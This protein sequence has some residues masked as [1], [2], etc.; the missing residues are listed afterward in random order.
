[1]A[2][3]PSRSVYPVQPW[4]AWPYADSE[5]TSGCR[6]H[7]ALVASEFSKE[8]A[9]QAAAGLVQGGRA[10][11]R[12]APLHDAGAAGRL[13]H[14]YVT[15]VKRFLQ[16]LWAAGSLGSVGTY[17]VAAQPLDEGL[18]QASGRPLVARP[19]PVRLGQ[20]GP[21]AAT[22]RLASG[23]AVAAG[24]L[25]AARPFMAA[26]PRS[27]EKSNGR[28]NRPAELRRV[29]GRQAPGG[30]GGRCGPVAVSYPGEDARRAVSARHVR[31]VVIGHVV[32]SRAVH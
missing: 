30:R 18:V 1:M 5:H 31:A 12:H 22:A 16:A 17:L 10:L 14:I 24:T 27:R 25:Q 19:R 8:Q 26:G 2:R 29:S 23:G 6:S 9:R 4:P 21:A 13:I 15:P 20:G 11:P 32:G 28:E 7:V 3:P